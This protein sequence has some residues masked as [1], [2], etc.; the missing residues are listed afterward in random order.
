MDKTEIVTG[1]LDALS[2]SER[3]LHLCPGDSVEE[4]CNAAREID[5]VASRLSGMPHVPAPGGERGVPE[6]RFFVARAIEK[7]QSFQHFDP[8]YRTVHGLE[9]V[10]SAAL[11]FR[12]GL[13]L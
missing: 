10:L 7:V 13:P 12:K 1:I 11:E 6:A 5:L 9:L 4:M 8:G 2:S 3:A